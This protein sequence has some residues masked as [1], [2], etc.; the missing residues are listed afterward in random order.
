MNKVLLIGLLGRDAE[1]RLTPSGKTVC[2]FS[3]ATNKV[4]LDPQSKEK[5]QVTQWHSIE[6][7]NI[8]EE[9]VKYLKKGTKV[10]VEGEI[11]YEEYEKEG[12][13]R[14]I[15]KIIC[16]HLELLTACTKEETPF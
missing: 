7:W 4:W 11:R 16:N 12:V 8:S 1:K 6:Y 15:S 5:N 13:K 9:L 2:V 3:I 14:S 10:L